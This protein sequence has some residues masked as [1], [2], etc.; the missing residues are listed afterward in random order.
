MVLVSSHVVVL[1]CNVSTQ[2]AEEEGLEV[3]RLRLHSEF[4]GSLGYIMRLVKEK[5][6]RRERKTQ[7][8]MGRC[9]SWERTC[10]VSTRT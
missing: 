2:K 7:Q 10:D 9:L 6:K 8:G 1:A 3:A 4:K 5:K